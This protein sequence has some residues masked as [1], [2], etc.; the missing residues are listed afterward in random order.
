MSALALA[1]AYTAEYGFGLLPCDLC[2]LQR[3]PF[4]AVIM[5]AAISLLTLLPILRAK[6]A[7]LQRG[8]LLLIG[9]LLLGNAGVALYHT[10]VEQ[11]WWQ[12]PDSCSGGD[13]QTGSLEEMR[14][15]ILSAPLIRCDVPAWEFHGLTMASLNI[16]FCGLLALF[17]LWR[18]YEPSHRR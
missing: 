7:W 4:F 1:G 9:L 16:I 18:W 11:R 14:A 13:I 12:G 6:A 5:L 15:Q 8:L 17:A 2:L 10:G 3:K